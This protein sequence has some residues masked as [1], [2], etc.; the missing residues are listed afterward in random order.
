MFFNW[1]QRKRHAKGFGI[2]S[3]FAFNFI[4]QIVYE[5]H[6]YYAFS[7]IANILSAHNIQ[8]T[9]VKINHL[10]YRV[11]TH[12]RP[13][14]ILEMGLSDGINTLYI[15]SA[16]PDATRHCLYSEDKKT[17]LASNLQ[18]YYSKN[19]E[20]IDK[21]DSS[22]CYDAIFIYLNRFAVDT[23]KLFSMS[24][25]NTFW[26]ISGIKSG[27]GRRLWKNIV[28]DKRSRITFDM[29]DIGIVIL[30]QSYNKR[31]YLI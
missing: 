17:L 9:N 12:F 6:G 21:V 7:D 24:S 22:E 16:S 4:T 23:D 31:H 3:P 25:D 27:N 1:L 10:S 2:H 11:V 15:G 28:K 26:V 19:V 5:K 18:E 14:T 13:K 29:K 20:I 8:E 30:K